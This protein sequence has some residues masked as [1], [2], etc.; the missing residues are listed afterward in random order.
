MDSSKHGSLARRCI[1]PR[2]L[3][4][5]GF[6]F[7]LPAMRTVRVRGAE[8]AADLCA[9]CCLGAFFCLQHWKI[10]QHVS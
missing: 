2:T 5:E 10:C 7:Q 6:I 8:T 9:G 1:L 4:V 3:T